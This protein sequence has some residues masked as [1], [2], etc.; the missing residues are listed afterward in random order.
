MIR[1]ACVLPG[2]HRVNRGAEVA[3]ESIARELGAMP[4]F[5]VTLIG[6]GES[7][8]GTPYD[9]VHAG[10]V[11]RERFERWPR[12][13]V[14]RHEYAYEE[15]TFLPGLW[16][17]YRPSDFDVTITCSYPFTN[18]LLRWRK[19]R[20]RRPLHVFVT[21]NGDWPLHR[22]NA[23]YRWFDCDAVVCINPDYLDA[24]ADKWPSRLIPNG[25]DCDLF[26]PGPAEHDRF[27]LSSELPTVLIV[28]ALAPSKRVIEGIRAVASSGDAQL[29]V[30][31]DGPQRDEVDLTGHRLLNNRFRRVCLSREQM[32]ALYRAADVFLHMSLDEPF[33]NVY[34]EA[35]AS[36]LP[37]VAHDRRVTRWALDR[38]GTYVDAE[39]TSATAGGIREAIERQG[40]TFTSEAACYAG[41]RFSWRTIALDYADF[42]RELLRNGHGSV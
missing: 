12:I 9:F 13:P 22:H 25:V 39:S 2:L 35:L 6:A 36:G 24:H 42:I 27:G 37:V 14:L 4:G 26:H 41:R 21:Q 11:P 29:V 31:G 19:S 23:E 20:G 28:S 10:C 40:P 1:I 17:A 5:E 8:A 34:I 33:G 18:W 15:L 3:F 7:R 32:P 30:A 16:G 38:F